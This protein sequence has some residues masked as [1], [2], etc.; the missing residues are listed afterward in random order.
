MIAVLFQEPV[1]YHDTAANNIAFGAWETHPTQEV[2]AEAARDAGAETPILQ[3]PDGYA[4]MLGKWFGGAELSV[5]EW[6][7]VALARAFLRQA[8]LIILDEPTSAMDSWAEADWLARFRRL[9]QGHTTVI[10]THRFTTAMQADVIHVMVGGRT[11]E[12]GTH[13]ELL[14]LN[15]RY[16]QSWHQQMREAGIDDVLTVRHGASE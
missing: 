6:Q 14:A 4:T 12:S 10:I 11:V 2:V 13:A 5:G 1:H 16:A 9:V 15:G 8:A 3:L 7:R